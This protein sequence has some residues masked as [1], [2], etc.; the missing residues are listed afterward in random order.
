MSLRVDNYTSEIKS[1]IQKHMVNFESIEQ[2]FTQLLQ[3]KQEIDRQ[4]S[5]A[6][7]VQEKLKK[8]EEANVLLEE[9]LKIL[10]Q[11]HIDVQQS[12]GNLLES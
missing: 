8:T 4:L 2:E 7:A 11:Q 5:K 12:A 1:A 6:R 10:E 3:N 9:K